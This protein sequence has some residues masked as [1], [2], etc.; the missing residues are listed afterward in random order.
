M[1]NGIQT[2][3]E[4][5]NPLYTPKITANPLIFFQNSKVVYLTLMNIKKVDRNVNRIIVHF[6]IF[7]EESGNF[8]LNLNSHLG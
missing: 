7:T 4:I 3:R 5:Q 8:S 1:C 6:I 2:V